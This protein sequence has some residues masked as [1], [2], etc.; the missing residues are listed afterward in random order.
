MPDNTAFAPPADSLT[1]EAR[2]DELARLL[3]GAVSRINPQKS[4]GNSPF[5]GDSSLDILAL[6]RRRRHQLRTRF[7]DDA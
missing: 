1:A 2:L 4:N 5:G 3:A 6:K 7:G